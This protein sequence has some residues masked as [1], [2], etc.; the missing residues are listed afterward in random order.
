MAKFA[1]KTNQ[2]ISATRLSYTYFVALLKMQVFLVWQKTY[3]RKV[4]IGRQTLW[5]TFSFILLSRLL[6]RL[7][8]LVLPKKL[9]LASIF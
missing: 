6:W 3:L 2:A 9:W 4:V 8:F 5:V 7:T 1:K